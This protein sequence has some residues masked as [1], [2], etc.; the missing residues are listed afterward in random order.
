MGAFKDIKHV[1]SEKTLIWPSMWASKVSWFEVFGQTHDV[2]VRDS[3]S[4]WDLCTVVGVV[5]CA[6]HKVLA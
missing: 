4:R 6:G 2:P 5:A 1:K 3:V